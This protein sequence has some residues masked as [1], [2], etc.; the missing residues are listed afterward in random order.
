MEPGS[1]Q[2]VL[3]SDLQRSEPSEPVVVA[4]GIEKSFGG[5]KV[6]QGIDIMI[7]AGSIH[8]L[9][10]EN[11]A[12][13]STLGRILAGAVRA[14]G[15]TLKVSGHEVQYHSPR[16][17][18]R[19]GVAL[20]AQELELVPGLTVAENI[21]LGHEPGT[22]GMIS[23]SKLRAQA[24][25]VIERAAFDLLPDTPV[26]ELRV[27]E[28]QQ[29]E[30]L[31]AI[32]REAKVIVMDEPTTALT[33]AEVEKLGELVRSL[34]HGGTAIVYVSHNL[35]EVLALADTI[36]VLRSGALVKTTEGAGETESSLVEAILGR[37]TDV[38]Y[39]ALVR[40]PE[41]APVIL[42]ARELGRRVQGD[43]GLSLEL[44]RGEILG[45]AGLLGS[46]RSRLARLLFQDQ[47]PGSGE[48]LIGGDPVGSSPRKAYD[49]GLVLL[50]EDRRGQGLLMGRSIVENVT[51]P[52][53]RQ[54][55][56]GGFVSTKQ[57]ST[58]TARLINQLNVVTASPRAA[59]ESLSGGNQQKVL[60][61][62]CLLRHPKV[63]I[64][65]EP[66]RGVD[67]GAKVSI[68]AL[69][70]KLAQE[71]MGVIVMSS[72]IEEVLGLAHRVLVMR[73]GEIVAD[74]AN[75]DLDA[76]TVMHAAFGVDVPSDEGGLPA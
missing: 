26:C 36:T 18:I 3:G 44:R 62:K 14:D 8:A 12:G 20:I 9:I 56:R 31:R 51:L 48:V 32:A 6:L 46:G 38:V 63:L 71:G 72:D 52:H 37:P 66:T 59:V 35:K 65:D 74:L 2:A 61:G 43:S 30:I 70:Q 45:V 40:P 67:I 47:D 29:V 75:D 27:A 42:S 34:A 4:T 57:C 22:G 69:I 28:R 24:I 21:M 23:R 15:G 73:N 11:G 76:S 68:Y 49:A 54:L 53:L 64:L 58:A 33:V 25:E 13:K 5:V 1:A 55:S 19:T 7:K 16:D 60:F 10:G 50:P 39:P 41:D 17:A